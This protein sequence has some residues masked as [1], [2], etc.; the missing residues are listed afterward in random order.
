MGSSPFKAK[1]SGF[2]HK[3]AKTYGE[4]GLE[5]PFLS[6]SFYLGHFQRVI[7]L[8]QG[9]LRDLAHLKLKCPVFYIK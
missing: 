2:L 7:P 9:L 1:M 6:N 4:N 5:T 3:M 8:I